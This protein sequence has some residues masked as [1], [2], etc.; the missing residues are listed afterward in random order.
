MLTISQ[1]KEQIRALGIAPDDT[2]LIHTS[3]R[4]IG[5]IENGADGLIDAFRECLPEGLFLVPT[6]T[7]DNVNRQNPVYDVRTSIPCIGTLPR[8][9]AFREDGYRSLHPTHSISGWGKDAEVFLGGEEKAGSPGPVGFAWANLARRNAKILLIGVGNNR[10]TFIHAVDEMVD[11][12]DRLDPSPYEI[13]IYGHQGETYSC[14]FRGHYCS[15]SNDVSQQ[16]VNFDR[17]F[18]ELGVWQEG[19]LGNARVMVVDSAK[20]RDAVMKIYSRAKEDLCI[21]KMD[22]A[23]QLWR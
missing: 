5:P 19:K 18:T 22:L 7:W 11:L 4:A 17:A 2:V 12:P 14:S 8:V 1:L 20:C 16:F 15:K 13:T 23:P 21:R 9:A 10:N 3:L 6:H